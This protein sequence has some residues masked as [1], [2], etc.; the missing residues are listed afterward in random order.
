MSHHLL[1]VTALQLLPGIPAACTCAAEGGPY[2]QQRC[3][4][5][6]ACSMSC[7]MFAADPAPERHL[8]RSLAHGILRHA[9]TLSLH[10][11]LAHGWPGH[12]QTVI[13]TFILCVQAGRLAHLR[14]ILWPGLPKRACRFLA[15]TCP[16][17]E[18]NPPPPRPTS[19]RGIGSPEPLA[20]N[21][22]S[23]GTSSA[24]PAQAGG[25][26]WPP[27]DEPLFGVI[28]AFWEEDAADELEHLQGEHA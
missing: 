2:C 11:R 24:G 8:M 1:Q 5:S 15:D 17:I 12:R 25:S 16:H 3:G 13:H 4:W 19:A 22:A 21:P 23:P 9:C 10:H 27:A 26:V 20:R 28:A 18:I 14:M 6:D 7:S